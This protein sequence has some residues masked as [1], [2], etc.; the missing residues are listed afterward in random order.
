MTYASLHMSVRALLNGTAHRSFVVSVRTEEHHPQRIDVGYD[1]CIH[2]MQGDPLHF[3]SMEPKR[4]L[5]FVRRA[6]DSG[7]IDGDSRPDFGNPPELLRAIGSL[8]LLRRVK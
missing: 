5:S 4:L 8:P 6:V 3:H 2:R 7:D 1:V